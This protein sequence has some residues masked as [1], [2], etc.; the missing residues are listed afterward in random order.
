[1]SRWAPVG[2]YF[3]PVKKDGVQC[4]FNGK[5]SEPRE[6]PRGGY[7]SWHDPVTDRWFQKVFFAARPEFRD[8]GVLARKDRSLREMIDALTPETN[9]LSTL[10]AATPRLPRGRNRCVRESA[11]SHGVSL[12]DMGEPTEEDRQRQRA[13][14]LRAQIEALRRGVR[15]PAKSGWCWS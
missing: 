3:D 10:E 13:E 2:H 7:L 1:L 11:G 14:E 8:L 12:R 6:V 15:A 4:S 9:R 5:I